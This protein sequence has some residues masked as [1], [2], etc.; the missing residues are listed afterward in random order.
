MT[1]GAGTT[2]TTAGGGTTRTTES[3][4]D[5]IDACALLTSDEVGAALGVE[6]PEGVPENAAT[7]LFGCRWEAP[8]MQIV[9]ITVMDY[10]DEGSAAG[11]VASAI[12]TNGYPEIMGIGDRA[13]DS[14]PFYDISVQVGRLELS[15]DVSVGEDDSAVAFG[16]AATVLARLPT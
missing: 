1:T 5:E 6:A 14:S 8:D 9:S 10:G 13:Y 7:M 12:E 15:V 3:G 2:A 16:L 11:A 4:M